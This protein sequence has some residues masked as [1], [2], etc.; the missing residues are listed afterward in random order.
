LED[1]YVGDRAQSRHGILT[2]KH[3]SSAATVIK[4]DDMEKI[5][6]HTYNELRMAPEEHPVLLTETPFN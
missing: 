3:S 6:H 1:A 2:L 4:R 5:W